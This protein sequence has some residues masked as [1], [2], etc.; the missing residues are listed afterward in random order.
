MPD[1]YT[2]EITSDF[3]SFGVKGEEDE[4]GMPL[5]QELAGVL[6]SSELVNM[7]GGRVGK[8]KIEL[9]NGEKVGF[10]GGAILDDKLGSVE[11]GTDIK[12][13]FDGFEKAKPGK[14]AMKKFQV[15]M[16]E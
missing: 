12:I 4:R 11:I 1:K 10:L 3:R 14:S 5:I 6:D 7:Q 8:Y 9:E 2:K 15:F 16:A 13:V